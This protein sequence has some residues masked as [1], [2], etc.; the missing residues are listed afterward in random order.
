MKGF[1]FSEGCEEDAIIS[2][3]YCSLK[4]VFHF[5]LN[6]FESTG[7][8]I[9]KQIYENLSFATALWNPCCSLSNNLGEK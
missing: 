5:H 6:C 3:F 7:E 8:I 1:L 2:Y 4:T 9:S